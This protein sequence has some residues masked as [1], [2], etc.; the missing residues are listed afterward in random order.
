MRYRLRLKR[1]AEKELRSIHP[2]ER[3]RIVGAIHDLVE[4]PRPAAAKTLT[5]V[6]AWS[7]R[8]GRYRVIYEIEDDMLVVTVI[9]IGH[10]RDV[11][12]RLR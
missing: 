12:R 8:I 1:S 11:Y 4:D 9:K 7:L 6:D 3:E 5:G 10:R 2:Q